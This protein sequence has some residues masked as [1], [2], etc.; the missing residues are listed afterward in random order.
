MR[1]GDPLG[2]TS[3]LDEKA[4]KFADVPRDDKEDDECD[5]PKS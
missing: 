3:G 4:P 2:H 5:D 1:F